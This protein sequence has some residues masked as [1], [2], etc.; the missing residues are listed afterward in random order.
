MN[1][2]GLNKN[3]VEESRAKYGENKLPEAKPKT[4]WDFFKDTVQGEDGRLNRILWLIVGILL[5]RSFFSHL[6]GLADAISLGAILIVLTVLAIKDGLKLQKAEKELKDKTGKRTVTVI[7]DGKPSEID[8]AEIVVGDI[9]L[10]E[11][12]AFIEADG[13]LIEGFISVDNS[14]LNGENKECKKTPISG[15]EFN[16]EKPI[17][18]KDYIDQNSVF[19]GTTVLSGTGKMIV[20]RVGIETENGKTLMLVNNVEETKTAIG[21]QINNI[22]DWVT[23]IG[24]V[25]GIIVGIIL[26]VMNLMGI[27]WA[28]MAFN[29]TCIV[30]LVSMIINVLSNAISIVVA[31]VPEGLPAIIRIITSKMSNKMIKDA[32]L[33]KNANRI[34]DAGCVDLIASDKTKT[35]TIGK[36]SPIDK[37]TADGIE[38]DST[39]LSYLK[40]NI[41]LNNDSIYDADGNII[42]GNP[43]AQALLSL[44]SKSEYDEIIKKS[45]VDDK[46]DFNSAWKYSAVTTN[47][48]TLYKGA[49][50]IILAHAKIMA[51]SGGKTTEIIKQNVESVLNKYADRGMRVLAFAHSNQPIGDELPDD[52]VLD[53]FVTMEDPL[54]PEVPDAIKE[55]HE[56]GIQV[57][58]VTGDNLRTAVAIAKDAGIYKEGDIAIIADEFDNMPDEEAK[59]ILPKL[60]VVG[61]ATP[62]T[63]MR[64]VQLAQSEERCVCMSG[65]GT[66]DAPALKAA[67]IGCGM[68]AGTDVC[69]NASD[70][71]ITDDNFASIVKA[72]LYG[73]TFMKNIGS[74]LKFQL[75]I[76]F[77]LTIMSVLCPI[78][79]GMP[80]FTTTMILLFNVVMDT[81]NAISFGGEPA[82]AEYM[83][84]KPRKKTDKLLS[85]A[86]AKQVIITTVAMV[87]LNAVLLLPGLASIFST[88]GSMMAARFALVVF[89]AMLGS[90]NIRTESINLFKDIL[91]SKT[92]IKISLA[93]LVGTVLLVQ[94]AGALIGCSAMSLLQWVIVIGLSLLIFPID[95][96]RKILMGN[97]T[98]NK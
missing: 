68:G 53:G 4:A 57:M 40:S 5:I 92:L 29:V 47:G 91:Q 54:R 1:M 48:V 90:F 7:R 59:A 15:Y 41:T 86:L 32:V 3:Q 66:N 96:M 50:E 83:K 81:L 13:Y 74:F 76:N 23:K 18:G 6:E 35:L 10:V 46:K 37:V 67:D 75:P 78:L 80:A 95:I 87:L 58:M 60:T 56:A 77:A 64:I 79:L 42:N 20:T 14:V 73:R 84:E 65:D 8:T 69:K 45:T 28:K 94:F 17:D 71:I 85:G 2:N 30:T 25:S 36:M 61:R 98:N 51:I 97:K 26:L 89:A 24:T 52:L 82:R 22:V 39:A 27:E 33:P 62:M 44:V 70:I 16:R 38:M 88:E 12:G 63:K 55:S 43:T 11:A 93:V 72:I 34:P 21:I 19:S 31:A 9:V 49:P